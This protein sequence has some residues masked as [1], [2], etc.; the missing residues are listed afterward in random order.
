[1]KTKEFLLCA[2]LGLT[3]MSYMVAETNASWDQMEVIKQDFLI[4]DNE[5]RD[6]WYAEVEYNS[7]DNEFM[8][9]W[10]SSGP[11]REDCDPGDLYECTANFHSMEGQRVSPDGNFLGSQITLFPP[12]ERY[13]NGARFA[14]N[15]F[16]NEYMTASPVSSTSAAVLSE[17]LIGRIN[18]IGNFQYGP[19]SFYPAG[20]D[21]SPL[22]EVIF[23]PVRR[24]YLV[25]YSARDVFTSPPD[26]YLNLIGFILNEDGTI[27]TGP[28]PV[29]NQ[30]GDYYAPDG[31][32]NPTDDT[33][34]IVWED[35]RNVPDWL[36][37]C[38]VYGALLDADGN[39]IVEIPVIDDF[40]LGEPDAGD[41][42]VPVAAYNPDKNKF[43]VVWE[44][45]EMPTVDDSAIFARYVNADGTLE[46][47]I[48][49][50]DKP[51]QQHWPDVVYV[52]EEQKFFVTWNDLRNDGLPKGS[53]WFQS[54]AI[55]VYAR[56]LDADGSPVGEEI[57]IYIGEGDQSM[58]Q[59][60]YSPVSDRFLI[61]WWDLNAPDDYAPLPGE[62]GGEFGELSSVP[63][64]MLLAGNV[65]GAIYGT[66]SISSTSSS[67]TTSMSPSFCPMSVIYGEHSEETRLLRYIRDNILS[68]THEGREL[69]KLYY[70]WSPEI[71]K[72]M[73]KDEAFKEEV[74]TM[75]DRMLPLLSEYKR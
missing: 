60:V 74:K 48:D 27:R 41:Q 42:R 38:D 75:I 30:L 56:W 17:I 29:G 61:T 72:A 52:E 12:D 43:F 71:A 45:D 24:E 49:I 31:A 33:Y 26:S 36:F 2:V 4:D 35:F 50:V 7:I 69:I 3:L 18:N 67:T 47:I 73:E 11:L 66:P 59:M 51:R 28:F 25:V 58:P 54:P 34:L 22:P 32:Y 39:M 13:K 44:A 14:H 68:K 40:A 21:S 8:V 53:D 20:T 65:G 46:P 6:Q 1:M 9:I 62:F 5:P 57:P 23:N 37:P 55:D 15:M 16:T 19:I 70:Q 10:R 63:M 64:G